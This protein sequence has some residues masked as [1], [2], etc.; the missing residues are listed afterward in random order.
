MRQQLEALQQLVHPRLEGAAVEP[1][2]PPVECEHLGGPQA[3][4]ERRV[5]A[6]HVEP[7]SDRERL[8]HHVV[9]QDGGAAPV[10]EQERGQ[11]REQRGLARPV[12]PEQAEDGAALHPQARAPKRG[13]LASPQ[14]SAPERLGEI[15][16]L[17]GERGRRRH[18]PPIVPCGLARS[19]G[20]GRV[21]H[22]E[23]I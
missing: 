8:A 3:P 13:G 17:D 4:H 7:A 19:G 11:D 1:V 6:R 5:A 23:P 9:A 22:V 16:S 20:R 18:D 21:A 2:E 10:G 12:G 15:V 14:P